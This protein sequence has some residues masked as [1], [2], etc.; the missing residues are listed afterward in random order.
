MSMKITDKDIQHSN[1][2]VFGKWLESSIEIQ[3]HPFKH[4]IIEDFLEE[5]AF[6]RLF[7]QYPPKPTKEFW[8]YSNPIEVKY[9]LDK[10]DLMGDELKNWF[11]SLS[12]PILIKKFADLFNIE[13]LE[14]DPYLHGGGI[15]MS[16]KHGRLNM[17]L[18]Y[19]KHPHSEKQRRLNIIYYVNKEWNKDWN[20]DCQLWD[21]EMKECIVKCYP[22]RNRAIVFETIEQSW[23]GLPDKIK[24][25]Q[26][27]FRKSMAYYYISP[28]INKS[29]KSKVG[30]GEDGFRMKAK[31][32]KRPQDPMDERMEKLYEI[33]PRKR[34]MKEDM[35]KIWP[36]WNEVDH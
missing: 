19:E 11:Y 7:A 33:R 24:C 9:A 8:S 18:D 16:P 4:V 15:H 12:H 20:G 3:T 1:I 34:I 13:N 6:E 25:P 32:V 36:E 17:H 23:H 35:E 21:K 10:F 2:R 22:K 14:F 5:K 29:D 28:L 26:A 31:F 30:A 27:E